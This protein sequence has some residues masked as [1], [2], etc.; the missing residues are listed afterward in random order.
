M[1][2]HE[3]RD[4]WV[5]YFAAN[6]H[7]IRPSVPLL[8][9]E[10]SILFTIAGMVPFIPYITGEEEAPWPRVASVQ[11]C[12]R[13]NDIENVGHTSRHGTFFQMNGNFSFGDYFKEGAINFAHDLLTGSVDE[14]KYGLDADR[15]WVTIWEGDTESYDVLTK[16]VGMDPR[17]IVR[18]SRDEN[19]W[20]TGQPGPA[21]PCC[22][23]HYDRGPEYGPEAVGGNVDPGGDRYLELWNLVFDQYMR[24]PGEGQDYPLLHELERKAIDTGAG[25][26]RLALVLQDKP[27]MF[28]IDEVRPV[29]DRV[30]E[31]ASKR[32]GASPEDDVL[33]RIIADHVRSSM[34]LIND[35]VRPGNDGAGY[36]LRRLV[37]RAVRSVR[38]LGVDEVTL[39]ELLPVSRDAMSPSYPDLITNWETISDVAYG[40]EVAFRRTLDS[41][42]MIFETAVSSAL[43]SG[44]DETPILSGE[45]AFALH[46]TY[47]FPIDLTLEMA[48]EKGLKVDEAKF[49]RLM[50]EQK[51]RAR[52]DAR[53][54]KAGH[55]D[56]K[57]FQEIAE[58]LGGGSE[59]IGYDSASGEAEIAGLLVNGASVPVVEGPQQV[60]LILTRTPFYAEAGGQRAD[61]G[62]IRTENGVELEVFDVQSPL[63]GLS[64][65]RVMV[66]EGTVAVGDRVFS[67]ID[68]V[69]RLAIARA[70]TSTHIVHKALH[71]VISSQATQAGSDN[72]PARMRLDFR[73]NKALTPGQLGD[74][75]S[76]VNEKMMDDLEI[77]ETV[78]PLAKAKEM[79]AMAL[80]G[81]KYGKDVRVVSIGGDWSMEICLGTHVPSTGKI[82]RLNVL[83][84]SSIGSGVRRID[85]LVSDS[86]YQFQAAE[87]ALVSQL[88]GMLHGTPEELPEKISTLLDKI[89]N[90]ERQ[91]GA[92]QSQVLL[93]RA[94]DVAEGAR[95]VHDVLVATSDMGTVSTTDAI[96]D[97]A[98]DVRNRLGDSEPAVVAL[99]GV[100]GDRP[101]L[102]VATNQ[103]ARDRGIRAG[104]LVRS[105]AKTLG[106]GGGGKPD[107]AQ[108]GG[109]DPNAV[110]AA[111]ENVVTQV[112]GVLS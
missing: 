49:R 45:E 103:L 56:V 1:R 50:E 24:G 97:V 11:K 48:S 14:G 17:H 70:H 85:A 44:T 62:T 94:V 12:I 18:L 36:V 90:A 20:S 21:G 15:L 13:T 111:L 6:G 51:E 46:D 96:R 92:L 42:T 87:H 69:R 34:M 29:I 101:Q 22:E 47:G 23:W 67:Q 89:K 106:G 38:L 31:I 9:P 40:E 28:E 93:S 35:G 8:S 32:Y 41:G 68:E 110:Q 82:G 59:F 64:V 61:Q 33:M 105:G 88:T 7:E 95:R 2:T 75:E 54:K 100:V 39:P 109:T 84:E 58:G 65:H 30:E 3:I 19:F 108:G 77:T 79:G 60:E 91:L 5:N 80:F 27:N 83:T 66:P 74:I 86:S 71:E 37:R 55:V 63:K 99:T 81:E 43:K 98:L 16:Q 73:H 52:A 72:S 104:D 10:P 25:L 78:M 112:R 4:R 102:V 57:V 53:A 107:F 76:M 26:E